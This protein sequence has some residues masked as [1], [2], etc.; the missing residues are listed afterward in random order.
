[1]PPSTARFTQKVQHSISSP[2]YPMPKTSPMRSALT[3]CSTMPPFKSRCDIRVQHNSLIL[4]HLWRLHTCGDC[5]RRM[6]PT[7][8]RRSPSPSTAFQVPQPL[9]SPQTL[10]TPPVPFQP[11]H[12]VRLTQKVPPSTTALYGS[13]MDRQPPM[14]PRRFQTVPQSR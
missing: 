2:R 12:Q 11:V 4:P 7:A 13:K 6:G 5:H 10:P 14:P 1:M 9:A 3:G 8:L